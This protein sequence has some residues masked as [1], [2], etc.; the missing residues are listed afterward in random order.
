MTEYAD[1]SFGINAQFPSIFEPENNKFGGR[2]MYSV[3]FSHSELPDPLRWYIRPV[4]DRGRVHAKTNFAPP[5]VEMSGQDHR[6]Q[7]LLE[8]AA[9]AR[10]KHR[11]LTLQQI[12]INVK[13]YVVQHPLS[14]V[15][16]ALSLRSV[17]L[18]VT[19]LETRYE[20]IMDELRDNL[21]DR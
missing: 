20:E 1:C 4:G 6:L 21:E 8:K 17:G 19:N 11:L 16:V 13:P 3:T 18:F 5:I 14:R 2:P 12:S 9:M 7:L 10:V 15:P